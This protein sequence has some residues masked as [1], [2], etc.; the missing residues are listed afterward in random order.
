MVCTPMVGSPT[1]IIMVY[2]Q[3][4]GSH[5]LK[6]NTFTLFLNLIVK[7]ITQKIENEFENMSV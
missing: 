3:F 2:A 6:A 5:K 4:G 7:R 1:I